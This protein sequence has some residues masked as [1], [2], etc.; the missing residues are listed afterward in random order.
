[1]KLLFL[2]NNL[3]GGGAE[4][5][6]VNLA[7]CLA[8]RGHDITVRVLADTGVNREFLSEK[9]RYE[10]VFHK[11][12]RGMNYLHKLPHKWIYHKVCHGEF[13]VIIPYLQGVLTKIVT[14]APASQKKVAWLHAEVIGSSRLFKI[15]AHKNEFRRYFSQYDHVACVSNLSMVSLKEFT[16]LSEGISVIYNTFDVDGIADKAREKLAEQSK[17]GFGTV[18]L[19]SVGKLIEIKGYMRL[20]R[21]FN[22]LVKKDNMDLSLSI[23]GEGEQRDEIERYAEENGIKER[24]FL[25]GFDANPYK[26]ISKSDLFVCSSYT[27]GFS[28]VVAESL[29]LGVPVLTT[30]C[31]GMDEMLGNNEYGIITENSEEALYNGL[32][33]ILSS[34]ELLSHYKLKAKE[35]SSF[36]SPEKT[37]NAVEQMLEA[38]INE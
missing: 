34:P 28:S 22:E 17:D 27:E 2:I 20:I 37:V 6:L 1:M 13:D 15:S 7:N 21:V 25:P 14:Y 38:V 5:V 12:F 35:R 31:P 16:G 18:K 8:A 32:K 3:G 26:Y 30:N 11:G 19:I 24:V 29:I 23:I 4:R 33:R 36:F 9:V 10:Y